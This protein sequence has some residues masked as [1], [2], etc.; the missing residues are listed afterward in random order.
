M[1]R[2]ANMIG[3]G[4][5]L[6]LLPL[7][8]G[9]AGYVARSGHN[10][11]RSDFDRFIKGVSGLH[12]PQFIT[13]SNFASSTQSNVA[14][15]DTDR[16]S[17]NPGSFWVRLLEAMADRGLPTTQTGAA[18]LAGVT[19]PAARKWRLGGYPEMDRV[20]AIAEKLDVSVNWL[21]RG[22]G[23][24]RPPRFSESD[25]QFVEMLDLWSRVNVDARRNLVEL[26]RMIAAGQPPKATK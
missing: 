20:I 16:M 21:L 6:G 8:Y 7:P 24:K 5:A 26:A 9:G 2:R 10:G 18:K 14:A 25:A 17:T 13:A 19:Q 1:S 23:P 3:L 22:E 15:G 4:Q 11:P 12:G